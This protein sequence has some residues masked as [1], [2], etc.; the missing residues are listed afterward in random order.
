MIR[1]RSAA[2]PR[3]NGRC[4]ITRIARRATSSRTRNCS[5]GISASRRAQAQRSACRGRGG[6]GQLRR[7]HRSA[8]GSPG[9]GRRQALHELRAVLRMRQLHGLLPADRRAEGS[10]SGSAPSAAMCTP[11][12]RN[13]SVATSAPT[14]A[15]PGISKWG[16][17]SKPDG[18]VFTLHARPAAQGLDETHV[19]LLRVIALMTLA[20]A[21]VANARAE[22]LAPTPAQGQGRALRRERRVHAA[23]S[24][25]DA[26][27]SARRDRP[28]G[29]PRRAVQPQ[30]LRGLPRSQGRRT[31][32]R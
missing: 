18:V 16:S 22:G 14:S 13:A 19:D 5:S 11:T 9:P 10:K 12:T 29:R 15:R 31:A 28:S 20:L 1:G 7:A 23:A 24:H 2:R 6:A 8:D 30:G 25:G 26:Q 17:G 32:N 3:P 21:L 27:A 4:T